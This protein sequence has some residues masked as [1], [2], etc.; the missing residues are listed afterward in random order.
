MTL[1]AVRV[2]P[3]TGSGRLHLVDDPLVWGASSVNRGEVLALPS[4]WWPPTEA[5][6]AS[7]AAILL[8]GVPYDVGATVEVPVVA[9]VDADLL[10]EGEVARVDGTA[11]TFSIDGVEEVPVV[12]AFLERPDGRILLLKRSPERRSYPECW[13]GVSGILEDRTALAQAIREVR[14]ETGIGLSHE[15]V[16]AAGAPVLVREGSRILV[17]HPFRFRV[18]DPEVTLDREH[19]RAEWI[20]PAAIIHRPTVPKLDRAWEAVAPSVRPKG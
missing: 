7:A 4:L 8:H 16:G 12:T 18:R 1:A 13:A 11:G 15:D 10:R 5:L 19:S 3:G 14:E 17:V 20:Q 2:A 6:P 9:G